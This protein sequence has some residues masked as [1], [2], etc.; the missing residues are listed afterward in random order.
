MRPE[1][2][3]AANRELKRAIRAAKRVNYT[4]T[5]DDAEDAWVDFLTHA[6]RIYLKLR[7]ACHGQPLDWSWWK[8]K[9]DERRDD[10]LLCYI[11][12]ARNTDTHRLEDTVRR[13]PGSFVLTEPG[14][15]EVNYSGPEHLLVLP[16][17][18]NGVVYQP[19][20]EHLGEGLVYPDAWHV[21]F[22]ARKYLQALVAEANSRLR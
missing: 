7:L 4:G 2:I 15:G 18:D 22:L 1:G 8:K 17:I 19:P 12:H 11:H 10:P 21:S 9:M 13:T 14:C 5:L 6:N 16:V 20:T 3:G